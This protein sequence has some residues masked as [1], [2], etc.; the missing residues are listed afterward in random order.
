MQYVPS[1]ERHCP[2]CNCLGDGLCTDRLTALIAE[3]YYP[4][5]PFTEFRAPVLHIHLEKAQARVALLEA[6]LQTMRKAIYD[7]RLVVQVK[8]DGD[9]LLV[10]E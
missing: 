3:D 8:L 4:I 5:D 10:P 1:R 6:E 7:S 9:Y 2:T